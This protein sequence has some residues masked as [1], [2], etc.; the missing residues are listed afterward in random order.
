MPAAGCSGARPRRPR[1]LVSIRA[2]NSCAATKAR[3]LAT[4]RDRRPTSACASV[5]SSMRGNVRRGGGEWRR[6]CARG[7]RHAGLAAA[8]T[9][10]GSR[11]RCLSRCFAAQPRS[12]A[13]MPRA[14]QRLHRQI[15]RGLIE[16]RRGRCSPSIDRGRAR[17]RRQRRGGAVRRYGTPAMRVL[18]R[19]H[20]E[21]NAP[22]RRAWRTRAATRAPA[23]RALGSDRRARDRIC[24]GAAASERSA[25]VHGYAVA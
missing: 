25:R 23:S 8:T 6:G 3:P 24:G 1:R 20:V 10:L 14:D 15:R 12:G 13:S 4:G 19:A 11:L 16:L 5:C 9:V 22:R 18:L 17:W 21:R 2:G 7:A